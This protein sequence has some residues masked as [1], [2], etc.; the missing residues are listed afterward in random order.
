V[1]GIDRTSNSGACLVL[2]SWKGVRKLPSALEKVFWGA[3]AVL[4]TAV[5]FQ[6]S[7]GSVPAAWFVK[8]TGMWTWR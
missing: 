4:G 2:G 7:A 6:P 5:G 1:E 8:I 3:E